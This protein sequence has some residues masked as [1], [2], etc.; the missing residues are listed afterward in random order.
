MKSIPSH[1]LTVT[2]AGLLA[3][4]SPSAGAEQSV[5]TSQTQDAGS[6][7]TAPLSDEQIAQVFLTANEGEI[8]QSRM[9]LNDSQSEDVK[10]FAR[11]MVEEHSAN[12]GKLRNL[13]RDNG[14]TVS[15]SDMNRDLKNEA[16]RMSSQLKDAEGAEV[17]RVYSQNAVLMHK[18]LL[19]RIDTQLLPN[20]KNPELKNY[21]K[22]TREHV[23]KHLE[24]AKKLPGAEQVSLTGSER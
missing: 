13:I 21:V 8:T 18:N 12:S 3:L 9:I 6:G 11:H 19:H 4:A 17:D 23:A 15:E 7:M 5:P 20:A 10:S 1:V 16:D 24:S 14:F 2:A 22:E